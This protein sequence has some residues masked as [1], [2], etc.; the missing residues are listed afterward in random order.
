[1]TVA[2]IDNGNGAEELASLV[3]DAEIF[4]FKDVKKVLKGEF[5]A[6]ILTDGD[7]DAKKQ[8]ADV[9]LLSNAKKPVLAIGFGYLCLGALM[10][11]EVVE[12]K[13]IK[14]DSV[15]SIK[16]GSPITTDMKKI[17]VKHDTKFKL[18]NIPE[19]ILNIAANPEADIIQDIEMPLIGVSFLPEQSKDGP[20]IIKNFLKFVDVYDNYHK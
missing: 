16:H 2:I 12:A 15:I 7:A 1:M 9:E 19:E 17:S 13:P 4:P 6:Y 3:G 5:D 8:S 14:K 10:G 11:A 18:E 20:Q